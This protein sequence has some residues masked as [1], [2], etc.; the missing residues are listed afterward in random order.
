MSVIVFDHVAQ[1][2]EAFGEQLEAGLKA[3]GQQGVSHAKQNV[4]EAVRV[5]TGDLMNSFEQQVDMGEKCVYIGTNQEYAIFN[6]I[7]TGIYLEGGGGRE[8]PWSYQDERG[9]WHTTRGMKPIHM[10]KRA[11]TEHAEEYGQIIEQYLKE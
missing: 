10:L 3:V 8:T 7:G 2:E 6:E 4:A 1:F 5:A 11:G 9:N